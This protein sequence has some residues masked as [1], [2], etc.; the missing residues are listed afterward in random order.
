MKIKVT[1]I[2]L[3]VALTVV[4]VGASA[5]A[6]DTN[7]IDPASDEL[8]LLRRSTDGEGLRDQIIVNRQGY[9]GNEAAVS[10][11]GK[12]PQK[13]LDKEGAPFKPA[14]RDAKL[15]MYGAVT[16]L[17]GNLNDQQFASS[18]NENLA[19]P[20]AVQNITW[21]LTEPGVAAGMQQALVQG[22]LLSQN[23]MTS[24]QNFLTQLSFYPEIRDPVARA[25]LSCVNANTADAWSNAIA[26]CMAD[27]GFEKEGAGGLDFVKDPNFGWTRNLTLPGQADKGSTEGN[28]MYLS[29]YLFTVE[30]TASARAKGTISGLM[31]IED[32]RLFFQKYV[33]DIE[34]KIVPPSELAG[35]NDTGQIAATP[36]VRYTKLPATTSIS[37]YMMGTRLPKTYKGLLRLMY[38]YCLHRNGQQVPPP[39]GASSANPP[40]DLGNVSPVDTAVKEAIDRWA[41]DSYFGDSQK[42]SDDQLKELSTEDF[43]FIEAYAKA[44]G[45][46]TLAVSCSDFNPDSTNYAYAIEKM[47]PA[48]RK[49]AR[50]DQQFLYAIA[51]RIARGQVLDTLVKIQEFINSLTIGTFNETFMKIRG[52]QLIYEA[53]GSDDLRALQRENIAGLNQTLQ[54]IYV[55]T[56]MAHEDAILNLGEK[57]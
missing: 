1:Y 39:V 40:A 18:L 31:G 22:M 47:A 50:P 23:K 16:G 30:A 56:T 36:L 44:L 48:R 55:S 54:F 4:M 35:I 52:T 46:F 14:S 34:F 10:T 49:Y 42:V 15:S 33:G 26:K 25:Y 51:F 53:A 12:F 11:L 37:D 3:V 8:N 43:T 38:G 45:I 24:E 57:K 29:E 13:L 19:S 21:A 2:F 28:K 5:N 41:S 9:Y 20:L 6:Q 32:I 27:K 7:P 17:Q